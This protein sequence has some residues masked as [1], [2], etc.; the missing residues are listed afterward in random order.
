MA[1]AQQNRC[2]W[3]S[4]IVL[5]TR[6]HGPQTDAKISLT[7]VSRHLT[8]PITPREQIQHKT[9]TTRTTT[10]TT[11]TTNDNDHEQR[12]RRH[13]STPFVRPTIQITLLVTAPPK[14]KILLHIF[15]NTVPGKII[16]LSFRGTGHHRTCRSESPLR[17]DADFR[18]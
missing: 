5:N 10:A 15:V 14:R 9:T 7:V 4:W 8:P 12:P 13:R 18:E 1:P 17:R 16:T 2:R 6:I 3:K 11:T